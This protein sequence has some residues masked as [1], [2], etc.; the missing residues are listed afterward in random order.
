MKKTI[1]IISIVIESPF[2][3]GGPYGAAQVLMDGHQIHSV[4]AGTEALALDNAARF[5]SRRC[6]ECGCTQLEGCDL[7]NGQ[8][9]EW[10]A[11]DLCS[12]CLPDYS[13][14]KKGKRKARRR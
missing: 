6:R 7:R 14:P 8:M 2:M 1:T 12:A 4:V 5:L 13:L 3:P 11:D 10:V 9:C